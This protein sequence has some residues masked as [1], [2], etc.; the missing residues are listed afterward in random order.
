MTVLKNRCIRGALQALIFI[1]AQFAIGSAEIDR[2][3]ALESVGAL[4]VVDNVDGLFVEYVSSAYQ[5]FFLNQNRFRFQDV[6]RG[7]QILSKSKIP[8]NQLNQD[9]EILGQL[10]KAMRVESLIRTEIQKIGHKYQFTVEWLHAPRMEKLSSDTFFIEE[11][12]DSHGFSRAKITEAIDQ[13]LM[14]LIEKVPFKAHITGRDHQE[15]TV[16]LGHESDIRPG[17]KLL[18]AS[19]EEVKKHPL[20]NSIVDWK[21]GSVGKLEVESVDGGIAFC[22]VMEED[23][24]KK[25]APY[26]KIVSIVRAPVEVTPRLALQEAEREEEHFNRSPT[27]GWASGGLWMGSFG[28]QFS[29]SNGSIGKAGGGFFTGAKA[30]GQLW[31]TRVWF[32]ELGMGYGFSGYSQSD[33]AT[34]AASAA[35]GASQSA[36]HWRWD[37]GYTYNTEKQYISPKAWVKLGYRSTSYSLPSSLVESTSPIAFKGF[38]IGVGG[39]F[40]LREKFGAKMTFDLGLFSSAQE[41]GDAAFDIQG[42]NDVSFFVGG[43]YR[44]SPKMTLSLGLDVLAHAAGYSDSSTLTQKIVSFGPSLLYSF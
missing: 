10:A 23:P 44:W 22:K 21:L 1:S 36:L 3:Y 32:T 27:L 13:S 37:V 19:L 42:A 38:F 33:I 26:Q 34:G 15:V 8:M 20:L 11:S 25:I 30:D 16:N 9:N 5:E 31:L 7:S 18:V 12:Q 41:T 24:G 14:R 29:T 39:D 40:P 6:S 35:T 4:P 17:D 43:Y 28:R 2:R